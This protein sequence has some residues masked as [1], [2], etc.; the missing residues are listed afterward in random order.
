MMIMT[1]DCRY[2]YSN[3][4]PLPPFICLHS[5]CTLHIFSTTPVMTPTEI[6]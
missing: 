5:P 2:Y 4:S 3:D 6:L 1:G